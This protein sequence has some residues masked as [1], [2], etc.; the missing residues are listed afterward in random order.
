MKKKKKNNKYDLLLLKL[1][2]KRLMIFRLIFSQGKRS[3]LNFLVITIIVGMN[4]L[5]LSA[6]GQTICHFNDTEASS[7]NVFAAGILDF[8]LD[9]T[10]V[11]EFIG[12]ELGEDI[13]FSSAATKMVGSMDIQ[14]EVYAEIMGGS[15]IFCEAL[16]M[17]VFHSQVFYDGDLL[18]FDTATTTAFGTWAFKLNLPHMATYIPHGEECNVDLV[19]KGWREDV[20][21]FDQS[22]FTDEER[23]H[24]RLTS[25]MIV[26]NEFLPRPDGEAYGFDFGDDSS[27]MPQGEWVE[28]YNNSNYAFDLAGWYIKDSLES[29]INKIMITDLNTVPATTMIGAKSWLVVYMNKAV[30]NNTGDTVKL[31][32]NNDELIDHYAYSSHDHCELEPTPGDENSDTTGDGSCES[33]PPNKTYARIPD[34]VGEWVDPVPTPGGANILEEGGLSLLFATGDASGG[35]DEGV[36]DEIVGDEATEMGG[37]T[38]TTEETEGGAETADEEVVSET[39]SEE[40]TTEPP[41]GGETAEVTNPPTADGQEETTE[42]EDAGETEEGAE[43]A[44]KAAAA[45]DPLVVGG[46]EETADEEVTGVGDTGGGEGPPVDGEEEAADPAEL[47]GQ[48]TPVE[49]VGETPAVNEY[50]PVGEEDP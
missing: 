38:E 39:A 12:I 6:I 36:N 28:I 10:N 27:N 19:F 26:L 21:D 4:G 22:G 43:T 7:A 17:E 14:Y 20:A 13:E 23:I 32:N 24:L 35:V 1:F 44:D 29:E 31:F 2:K 37:T 41:V 18:S 34:G 40:V 16:Q 11:E 25:R 5:G 3:V 15:N 46:Q 30:L 45:T 33:V 50:P 48:E 49:E 47:D 9:N 8:S 42:E